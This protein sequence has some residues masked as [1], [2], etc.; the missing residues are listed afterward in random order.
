MLLAC[1][2]CSPELPTHTTPDWVPSFVLLCS[3]PFLHLAVVGVPNASALAT[4]DVTSASVSGGIG[5]DPVF[6][7][8]SNLWSLDVTG[9]E[10]EYYN[11]TQ[12]LGWHVSCVYTQ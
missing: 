11:M 10:D 7:T 6:Q 4:G 3:N 1:A 2:C 9:E 12:V 5:L 8:W